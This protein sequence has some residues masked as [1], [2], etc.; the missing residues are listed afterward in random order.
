MMYRERMG[1]SQA[2]Q[3]C[4][5][6]GAS[7][8]SLYLS[9]AD[10]GHR[11]PQ[12]QNLGFWALCRKNLLG[13]ATRAAWVAQQWVTAPPRRLRRPLPELPRGPA[14]QTERRQSVRSTKAR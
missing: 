5:H 1:F 6:C 8:P 3:L 2:R 14:M 9:C 7:Q 13:W 12:T 4:P 11:L 10:C